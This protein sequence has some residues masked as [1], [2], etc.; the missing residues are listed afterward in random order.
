[1]SLVMSMCFISGDDWNDAPR[2]HHVFYL[3]QW[4]NFSGIEA[5]KFSCNY[6]RILPATAGIFAVIANTCSK[7]IQKQIIEY[8]IKSKY[9]E[10]YLT[11]DSEKVLASKSCFVWNWNALTAVVSLACLEIRLRNE[12]AIISTRNRIYSLKFFTSF[13][14]DIDT[15][16]LFL[17]WFST[18]VSNDQKYVRSQ[19]IHMYK[20][21]KI[22]GPQF[23]R[24][25]IIARD[26]KSYLHGMS[27]QSLTKVNRTLIT[28][29]FAYNECSKVINTSK[30][31]NSWSETFR[32]SSKFILS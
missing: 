2:S 12:E 11:I 23:Q 22:Q 27:F 31:Y 8:D 19:A 30:R 14:I 25:Y 13:F 4:C 3:W 1:M 17:N 32:K 18:P 15:F 6:S 20:Y 29:P 21:T 9:G 24:N 7:A 16:Y 26:Q 5:L 10:E 28:R